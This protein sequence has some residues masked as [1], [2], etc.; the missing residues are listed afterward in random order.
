[1]TVPT[2]ATYSIAAYIAAHTG[3]LSEIDGAATAG[4]V[5]IRDSTDALLATI[6]LNGTSGA[7]SGTTGVLTITEP[8]QV[9]A[10]IDGTAAYAELTDGDDNLLLSLPVVAGVVPVSGYAVLNT[11]A[12]KNN[13]VVGLVSATIG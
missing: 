11:T 8:A 12:I 9:Q 6:I 1:M 3:L 4:K 5:F 7:V 10:I 2:V 13:Q